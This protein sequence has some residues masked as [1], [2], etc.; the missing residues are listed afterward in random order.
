M[1]EKK[2]R[3]FN[4][5]KRKHILIIT[6]HGCHAPVI[7][8]TTDTGGQNFYVNGL[9]FAL[10][11]HRYKVT[12]LNR[13]GYRHP[14]TK[15][16]HKGIVYYDGVW[17]EKG[18]YCRL[19]YL[20][21]GEN[22]FIPKE[23]LKRHNLIQEKD[24]FFSLAKEIGMKLRDIYFMNSHYWDGGVLGGLI[25][26]ELAKKNNY[27]I[28]HIWTPHSL[29][30]L[31]RESYQ[32]TPEKIV[33][34]LNFPSRIRSEEELISDVEGIVSTSN[35]INATL[36]AEYE[37]RV[38][39]HFWFPPGVNT[40]RFKP[41]RINQCK[42]ALKIIEETL[43]MDKEEL[44]NLFKTNIVFLETSRTTESKQKD[45]ILKSFSQ[46][47]NR[48]RALLIINVDPTTQVYGHIRKVY[49]HLKNKENIVLMEK[50]LTE[51]EIAQIFSLANVYITTSL[52]EGWG[53]AVLEAAASK[54]AVISS[55]HVPFVTEVLKDNALIVNKNDPELYAEK[56]DIMIQEPHLRQRLAN[57][58]HKIANTHYSWSALAK[59]FMAQ[60]RKRSIVD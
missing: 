6:N 48:N 2:H 35:K 51:E 15:V 46:I 53:M 27:H 60:M 8:V 54:C 25:N 18:I 7:E 5:S 30:I 50:Y 55:K 26:E 44:I 24:F 17:G 43:G 20:E 3:L 34:A 40:K 41:R 57:R 52:M 59:Q 36:S 19:I 38:K 39:N 58:S 56:I 42:K 22:R 31:K 9:S 33:K 47:N 4:K 11:K 32:E 37:S 29:G 49:T 28:P 12:I 1:E 21:D 13:G 10:V 14:I 45:M 16:L 23:R